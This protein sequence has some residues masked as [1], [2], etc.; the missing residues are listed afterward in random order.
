MTLEEQAIQCAHMIKTAERTAVL[1]GAGI[2]TAARIP[3]FRG[4]HGIY[5]RADVQAD[6]LFDIGYF[7][8]DPSYYYRFHRECVAMLKDIRPTFTHRFLAKLEAEGRLAGIVTQNFD[9]LHEAAGSKKVYEIH[10]TIRHAI[11]TRCGKYH[12]YDAVNRR[13]ERDGAVPHCDCGGVIKPDIVFFGESVKYLDQCQRLCSQADLLFILGSS[14]NVVP[15][16]QLPSLC[17]G[18]IVVVNKGPVSEDYLPA[19]RITLRA[20]CDLDSF[21]HLVE[22]HL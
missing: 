3:D 2:S 11:C 19:S 22:A 17:R 9:G 15:A 16:A 20:D 14:L 13:L 8:K 5:H 7:R 21:F 12:G 6:L 1:S 10:G 4:P 18:C